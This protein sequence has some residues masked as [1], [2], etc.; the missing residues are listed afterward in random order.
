MK[1]RDYSEIVR[2]IHRVPGARFNSPSGRERLNSVEAKL[3]K[4]LRGDC[5]PWVGVRCVTIKLT[6]GTDYTPTLVT[7]DEGVAVAWEARTPDDVGRGR[8]EEVGHLLPK[9]RLLMFITD[10]LTTSGWIEEDLTPR[11]VLED[12]PKSI[13]EIRPVLERW[14]GCK[15]TDIELRH[16]AR[17]VHEQM[18]S[19]RRQFVARACV[20]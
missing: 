2:V 12:I 4:K 11:Y 5:W 17:E 20:A 9:S 15:L 16:Y 18:E 19:K 6:D 3:A 13:R 1:L 7:I 8:M 10:Y 14:R